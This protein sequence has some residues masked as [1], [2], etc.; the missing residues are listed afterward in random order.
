MLLLMAT[1][2]SRS[3]ESKKFFFKLFCY[4]TEHSKINCGS[5]PKRKT[6]LLP[7]IVLNTE[8]SQFMIIQYIHMLP[9]S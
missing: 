2:I 1:Y 8:V 4:M 3:S 5:Q 6:H 7:Y 9:L